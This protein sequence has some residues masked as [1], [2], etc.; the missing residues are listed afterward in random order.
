M[1]AA[2][3]WGGAGDPGTARTHRQEWPGIVPGGAETLWG[4]ALARDAVV[5]EAGGDD[6]A[7]FSDVGARDAAVAG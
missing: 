6:C 7:G 1:R 3:G 5:P 2:A 4:S